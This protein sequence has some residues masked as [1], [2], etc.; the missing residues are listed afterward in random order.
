MNRYQNSNECVLNKS[1]LIWIHFYLRCSIVG[2]KTQFYHVQSLGSI[3]FHAK[4]YL[5][6]RK[7]GRFLALLQWCKKDS[8]SSVSDVGF[9][10][11]V[12]ADFNL[13]TF[14][15]FRSFIIQ[16]KLLFV[17]TDFKIFVSYEFIQHVNLKKWK[18]RIKEAWITGLAKI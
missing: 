5:R 14:C 18:W 6:T 11:L 15:Y 1:F 2:N 7:I 17:H 10:G 8:V 3:N 9:L 12:K 13:D 4:K 16:I